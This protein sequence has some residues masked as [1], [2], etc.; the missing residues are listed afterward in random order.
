MKEALGNYFKHN[1]KLPQTIVVYRDGVGGPSM[2]DKVLDYELNDMV[3]AMTGFQKDYTPN[4]LYVFVDKRINTRFCEKQGD[5]YA[6]PA[7]GTVIDS[8][9]IGYPG[10]GCFD[11]YLVPHKATVATA[12]PVHYNVR[13]NTTKLSNEEVE[14]LTYHLCYNYYNFM[15]SIKVPAAVMYAHKI[16]NYANDLQIIPSDKLKNNLHYL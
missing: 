5:G 13:K 7:P 9:V 4:I 6:N 14:Q 11:F 15:G 3:A 2:Q 1:R 16:A 12:L 10:K 8:G